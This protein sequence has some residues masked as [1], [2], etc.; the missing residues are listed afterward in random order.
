MHNPHPQI[1][2][3]DHSHDRGSCIGGGLVVPTF[4]VRGGTRGGVAGIGGGVGDSAIG[5][6]GGPRGGESGIGGGLGESAFGV[7]GGTRTRASGFAFRLP[8]MGIPY[9]P[10]PFAR[11]SAPVGG[12]M[13]PA[14]RPNGPG[15]LSEGLGPGGWMEYD[16]PMDRQTGPC[17]GACATPDANRTIP[18]H[19]R[20]GNEYDW[21]MDRQSGPCPGACATPGIVHTMA[22]ITPDANCTI[23]RATPDAVPTSPQ[24]TPAAICMIPRTTPDAIPRNP[25]HPNGVREPAAMS[26][27]ASQSIQRNKPSADQAGEE[28]GG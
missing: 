8:F 13:A 15:E 12:T 9:S 7:G 5:V 17:P 1:E 28:V 19:N 4:G 27:R 16:W 14:H 6:G 18:R 10:Q 23:P 25:M 20:G 21:P 22:H 24:T 26:P 3:D 11:F 2:I